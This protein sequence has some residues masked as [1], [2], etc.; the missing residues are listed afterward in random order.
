MGYVT[1]QPVPRTI[2][3]TITG[4]FIYTVDKIGYFQLT[5]DVLLVLF[6][7]YMV[8]KSI[9]LPP[10]NKALKKIV[11]EVVIELAEAKQKITT[12]FVDIHD[13]VDGTL[14]PLFKRLEMRQRRHKAAEEK[15]EEVPK[16]KDP[17]DDIRKLKGLGS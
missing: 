17:F 11:D 14:Q 8:S 16:H 9:K 3:M 2:N 10:D 6:A 12:G 13:Y 1:K 15:E 5:L 4:F 7:A